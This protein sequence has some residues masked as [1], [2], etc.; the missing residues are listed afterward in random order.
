MDKRL[1]GLVFT[2]CISFAFTGCSSDGGSSDND[3][4]TNSGDLSDNDSEN[5]NPDDSDNEGGSGNT[6]TEITLTFSGDGAFDPPS[7]LSPGTTFVP[8]SYQETFFETTL[9]DITWEDAN[10]TIFAIIP[11]GEDATKAGL[12]SIT[13][14]GNVGGTAWLSTDN[15]GDVNGAQLTADAITMTDVEVSDPT[16]TSTMITINGRL[17]R[18]QP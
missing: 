8:I 4:D 14:D 17:L 1:I 3:N 10:G 9:L 12:V 2:L 15:D 6:P 16:V 11:N 7:S 5:Q 18:Q 13:L